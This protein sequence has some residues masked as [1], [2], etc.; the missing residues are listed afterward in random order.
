MA[1]T[2]AIKLAVFQKLQLIHNGRLKL[3]F[4]SIFQMIQFH[5]FCLAWREEWR[6]KRKLFTYSR[7]RIFQILRYILVIVFHTSAAHKTYSWLLYFLLRSYSWQ[8]VP[9][10]FLILYLLWRCFFNFSVFLIH[11]YLRNFLLLTSFFLS[12]FLH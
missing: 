12:R 7:Q 1:T 10:T 11:N 3:S 8:M 4:F 5:G 9:H 6:L 2:E